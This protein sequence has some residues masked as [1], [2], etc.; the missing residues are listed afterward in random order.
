MK[1][2]S[3]LLYKYFWQ[4]YANPSILSYNS[5]TILSAVGAQ[6]GD[7]AAAFLFPLAIMHIIEDI[8]SELIVW[9]QDD[10]TTSDLAHI[11]LNDFAHLIELSNDIGLKINPSKCELF[12]HSGKIDNEVVQK[13]NSLE[14]N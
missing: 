1:E 5:N 10:G 6:Q 3:P 2:K 11:V 14:L 13:L 7:P 8:E 12:F 9:Y 4:Y